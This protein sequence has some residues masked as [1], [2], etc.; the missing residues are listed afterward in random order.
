MDRDIDNNFS[1]FYIYKKKMNKILKTLPLLITFV[2][3]SFLL[4]FVITNK[5]PSVPPSPLLNKQIPIFET[6]DLFDEK[7][8]L[9]NDFLKNKKV[10]IN[11]FASWCAPCKIEHPILM[12]IRNNN[13]NILLLGINHKDKKENAINFVL[14]NGNPYHYIGMDSDGKISLD[15]GVYG[16]PETFISNQ[17]EKIIFKH[18]GPLTLKLYNE[19]IKKLLSN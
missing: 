18:V 4:Y 6:N 13:P 17:E 1:K 8:K 3:F 16:L 19:Q 7:I 15:F 10:I 12:E 2:L 14:E 11:F 9:D 5:D